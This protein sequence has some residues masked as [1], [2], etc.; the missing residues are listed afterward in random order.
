M[1]FT[2]TFPLDAE[3][4]FTVGGGGPGGGGAG[5]T[6][7]AIDGDRVSVQN[8]RK[9]RIPVAAGPHTI[10]VAVPDRNRAAGVDEIYSDF[11]VDA[12]FRVAGG[13]QN[14]T[15]LGPFEAKG[16]GD[17][18]ARRRVF[19]CK[20]ATAAEET[21][22]AKTILTT[23]ARRAY[24][25]PVSAAEVE[26]LMKFYQ[27]GRVDEG[28]DFESGIQQGL[29]RILVAPRFVFRV[30]EEPK[31]VAPGASYRVSDVDLASRLSFFLWSS[32]PDDELLDVATKGRLKDPVVLRA[33]V[34]RMLADSKSDALI[35][36]FA[37]QW[38]FLRDLATVQTEA[39]NFDDN[40]RKSFQKETEM[41]FSTIVR[42]D[43]SL[44]DL[45]DAD[46]TFVDERLAQHY[47]IPNIHGSYFRRVS[48]PANSP[49]R[50]LLGEGSMTSNA[51]PTVASGRVFVASDNGYLYSLDAKTG[52]V[53]WSYQQGSIVRGGPTVGRITG[54]G[55]ARWAVFL[56]DGHAYVHA[57]D[58]QTGRPLWKVRVDDHPVARIT[59][60]LAYHDGRVYVP[61]SGSE[62]FNAGQVDYPCCTSR[63][64]VVALD[65]ST[66]K[67]VW[68]TYNVDEPKPWFRSQKSICALIFT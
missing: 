31:A 53:Y 57:V 12:E 61:V 13:I 59:A 68:K 19:T 14:V 62:E 29:A 58:A 41:L 54:Q 63:G 34:K 38:L 48:L 16:A 32:I 7:F 17:T 5:A 45:L 33:Q 64:A 15:I 1:V 37:G 27:Q 44:V 52:C 21:T 35:E 11:R 30:E 66:G 18:P 2:H 24:R 8:P 42:E 65:A 50:G 6:D 60:S 46:Y 39:K 10:A 9:F 26:T 3:Y 51:Q 28:A 49:R 43:R 55:T 56:G 40:L 22:C 47:G 67:Q 23:L 25:G 4:E 36:N 20:P